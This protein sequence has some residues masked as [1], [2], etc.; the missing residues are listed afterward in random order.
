MGL[1]LGGGVLAALLASVILVSCVARAQRSR[2]YERVEDAPTRKVAIVFGAAVWPDGRLSHVLKDRVQTGVE[3]Y[4]AGKVRKLLMT[5]DNS[6]TEYN[7]PEAM[8][9][10]AVRLGVPEEDVVLDYAGFRTYDS[11]YR[12]RDV[13][14]LDEAILVTQRFHLPRTLYTARKLGLEAVGVVADRRVYLNRKRYALR[15]WPALLWAWIELNVTRPQPHFLGE[16]LPI[17]P[18]EHPA[19]GRGW[20]G[21]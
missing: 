5:G 20:K 9:K 14:G 19:G 1:A 3:L 18:E 15:E 2:I 11:C 21:N 12:A 7:E 17:F 16:F 10:E 4:R 6:R 13:F 8:K